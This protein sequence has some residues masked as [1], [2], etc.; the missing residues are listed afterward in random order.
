[1]T[2]GKLYSASTENKCLFDHK[3]SIPVFK[4]IFP[5]NEMNYSLHSGCLQ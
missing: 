5:V 4:E 1:M 2:A 3:K